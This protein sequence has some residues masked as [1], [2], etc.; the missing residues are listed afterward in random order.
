M[1]KRYIDAK[2]IHM[3]MCIYIVYAEKQCTKHKATQCITTLKVVTITEKENE[4]PWLHIT[5]WIRKMHIRGPSI[6]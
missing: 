1:I 2:S 5:S 4:L 3:Y 6:K